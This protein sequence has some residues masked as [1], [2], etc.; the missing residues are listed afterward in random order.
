MP[1]A[2]DLG[3][4]ILQALAQV[5]S[6]LRTLFIQLQLTGNNE[7]VVNTSRG[8]YQS[9]WEIWYQIGAMVHWTVNMLT[10]RGGFIDIINTNTTLENTFADVVE[11]AAKNATWMIGDLAGENSTTFII[12]AMVNA[13]SN[14]NNHVFV[15]NLWNAT[16]E[17]IKLVADALRYFPG[18]FP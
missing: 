5:F 4:V 13:L 7:T 8:A 18:Y 10:G 12:K 9:F 17:M 16:T 3:N 15:A 2:I 14:P 1:T 6:L 11:I